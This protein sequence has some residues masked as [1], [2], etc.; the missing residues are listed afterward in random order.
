[1]RIRIMEGE[2][3]MPSTIED[4]DYALYEYINDKINAFS[5]TNTGWKKVAVTWVS[6]ERAFQIKKTKN[7]RDLTGNITLPVITLERTGLV[8]DLNKKGKYWGAAPEYIDAGGG[9]I[10]IMRRINQE[11]TS[12][13]ANADSKRLTGQENMRDFRN[14]G[15]IAGI[16]PKKNEKI[17]YQ[18]ITIPQPVYVEAEYKL[19]LRTEYQQQMNEI[20][21]PFITRTKTLNNFALS[22]NNHLYEGFIDGNFSINNNVSDMAEEERT[23]ETGIDIRIIGHLIGDGKNQIKPIITYRENRVELKIGREKV[24]VGDIPTHR[25]N[26]GSYRG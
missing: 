16:S 13:Y 21:T 18:H 26:E 22:R 17:V 9:Q 1:M 19:M 20:I 11:K 5:S 15:T 7:S 4:I 3:I 12:N 24:I 10:T 8:K 23:Y 2:N 25:N 6:P 14:N